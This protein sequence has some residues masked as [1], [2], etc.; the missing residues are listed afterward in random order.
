M[1]RRTSSRGGRMLALGIVGGVVVAFGLVLIATGFHDTPKRRASAAA[2]TSGFW[3]NFF[4]RVDYL[5]KII[6]G[7][8][9]R[10]KKEL[11]AGFLLVAIGAVM[12]VLPLVANGGGSG[13]PSTPPSPTPSATSTS[14]G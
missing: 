1:V 10:A 14:T 4:K 2:T 12:L 9:P 8:G 13:S 7:N 3:D 5:L 6:F 11:A